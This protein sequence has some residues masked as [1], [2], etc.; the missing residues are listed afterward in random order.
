MEELC[1]KP[2]YL[3]EVK[4]YILIFLHSAQNTSDELF[5]CGLEEAKTQNI[6]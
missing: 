6:T 1:T 4:P 5:R 3:V 2:L